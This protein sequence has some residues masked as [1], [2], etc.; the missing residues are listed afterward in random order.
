MT[1]LGVSGYGTVFRL[2]RNG[3]YKALYSNFGYSLTQPMPGIPVGGLIQDSHG[4]LYGETQGGI[5]DDG[6]EYALGSVFKLT[7][8]GT[9]TVLYSFSDSH[10]GD[11]LFPVGGLTR[12]RDGN[13]YGVTEFGGSSGMGTIFR[14]TPKVGFTTLHSFTGTTDGGAPLAGLTLGSNGDFYGTTS[15]TTAFRFEPP[16]A[17]CAG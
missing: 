2:T 13:L 16:S 7:P 5:D 14:I 8:G 1:T 12:G 6:N 10:Y 4:N 9:F 3:D 17:E 15:Y 11:G